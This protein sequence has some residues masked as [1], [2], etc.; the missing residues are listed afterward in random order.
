M[1]RHVVSRVRAQ[2]AVI[3]GKRESSSLFA[4]SKILVTDHLGLHLRSPSRSKQNL[5]PAPSRVFSGGQAWKSPRV[6]A[7]VASW[8]RM[9]RSGKGRMVAL[10][11]W[12]RGAC[13]TGL[14]GDILGKPPGTQRRRVER[15]P[16]LT[17]QA[18]S[19]T[20]KSGHHTPELASTLPPE[21]HLSRAH[22]SALV[23]AVS[24]SSA[25]DCLPM[26]SGFRLQTA[27]SDIRWDP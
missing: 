14:S 7:L 6:L 12:V 15:A 26:R 17:F 5:P 27:A 18:S 19:P 10:E 13:A 2:V 3:A 22:S 8:A 16:L 21:S 1:R 24:P 4:V 11:A 9:W 25:G 23:Y 20:L